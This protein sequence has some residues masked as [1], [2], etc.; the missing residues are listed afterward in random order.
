LSA[1]QLGTKYLNRLLV[2]E[3]GHYDELGLLMIHHGPAVSVA[4]GGGVGASDGRRWTV[5]QSRRKIQTVQDAFFY[6]P[7]R[8]TIAI[9][10]TKM[11]RNYTRQQ[12]VQARIQID[13]LKVG[14]GAGFYRNTHS[15]PGQSGSE[16]GRNA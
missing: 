7:L 9:G 4:R 8:I 12:V 2:V 15:C 1:S 6:H 11:Q 16:N 14:I 13:E 10:E 3:R 5:A